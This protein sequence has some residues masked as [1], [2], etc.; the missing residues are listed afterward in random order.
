M[1]TKIYLH[2]KIW[3]GEYILY[4]RGDDV[5]SQAEQWIVLYGGTTVAF[6]CLFLGVTWICCASASRLGGGPND[7]KEIMQHKF[8]A[9]I[10]WQDV[11]EKKV[12]SYKAEALIPCFHFKVKWK[13]CNEKTLNEASFL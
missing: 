8:F 5:Y 4:C 2:C 3:Q 11:Y 7:A 6:V 1:V 12:G 9:G 10:N 13:V